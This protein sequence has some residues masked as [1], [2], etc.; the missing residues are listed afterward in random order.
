MN[1]FTVINTNKHSQLEHSFNKYLCG[2]GSSLG[3]W[4]IGHLALDRKE[5]YRKELKENLPQLSSH[6]P[7]PRPLTTEGT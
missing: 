1:L 5:K 4:G 2:S 7:G 6:P 3:I